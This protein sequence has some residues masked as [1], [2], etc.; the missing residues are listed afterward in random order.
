V[1]QALISNPSPTKKKKK[2]SCQVVTNMPKEV[3]Y[4]IFSTLVSTQKM[5]RIKIYA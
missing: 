4:A 5:F 3:T 1:A 2:I